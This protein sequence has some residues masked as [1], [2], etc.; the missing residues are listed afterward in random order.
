MAK[1]AQPQTPPSP[2][3]IEKLMSA[4]RLANE[5]IP[6]AT[7]IKSVDPPDRLSAKVA[8]ELLDQAVTRGELFSYPAK[9][10]KGKPRYWDRNMTAIVNAAVM[11]GIT[12]LEKPLSA[13][14]LLK[15]L[16]SPFK[17]QVSEIQPILD[18]AV[19]ARELF[20][21]P[22]ATS[23]GPPRFWNHDQREFGRQTLLETVR[24]K[25]PQAPASLVKLLKGFS[26][27]QVEPIIAA[28]IVK[29]QLWRHPPAGKIK[30]ELLG[31][32]P[33]A[34]AA[35]LKD[36]GRQLANIVEVL[37]GAGVPAPDVRRSIIEMSEAA[38]I[39]FS[40]MSAPSPEP[41]SPPANSPSSTT[42]PPVDLIELLKKLEPAA[43]RGAL[44]G[45]AELR[46]VAGLEKTVFDRAILDLAERE[47]L[48]LHR[49]DYPASLS[50]GTLADLIHDGRGTYYVGMALRLHH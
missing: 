19:R 16:S 31:I 22:P 24:K 44:V 27:E 32:A 34:P 43:V 35:Y 49:H 15:Q 14:D 23:K 17:L 9:T 48:T 21:F 25:G 45:T 18:E 33:P 5:P 30:K 38:G 12:Q 40:A 41:E 29:K 37:L 11:T 8:T 1:K 46:R 20:E 10:A 3:A 36:V 42:V 6:V 50:P 47:Q 26:P 28:M 2:N 7:L 39:S 4:V 13:R